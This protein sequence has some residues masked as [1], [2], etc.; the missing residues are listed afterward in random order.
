MI[1]QDTRPIHI[2]F[3]CIVGYPSSL[4]LLMPPSGAMVTRTWLTAPMSATSSL[5][6]KCCWWA[7][8]FFLGRRV[9]QF[10]GEECP[11]T[12]Q[13]EM[14]EI[15]NFFICIHNQFL[16]FK[17][18]TVWDWDWERNHH[19]N[20]AMFI[21]LHF[22][23]WSH[24]MYLALNSAFF[25]RCICNKFLW[26]GNCNFFTLFMTLNFIFIRPIFD[27]QCIIL[28]SDK[29]KWMCKSITNIATFDITRVC[30][31]SLE[32]I[33]IN[34]NLKSDTYMQFVYLT[35]NFLCMFLNEN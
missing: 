13:P 22:I 8:S 7:Q 12:K 17:K 30:I 18:G 34:F 11:S 29:C 23:C 9:V 4:I 24:I 28:K 10:W 15:A 16:V 26:L 25:N 1:K 21:P 2:S 31:I 6:K 20:Y 5:L 27:N 35:L 33:C 32:V 14:S 3:C 19:I